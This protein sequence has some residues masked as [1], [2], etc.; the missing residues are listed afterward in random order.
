MKPSRYYIERLLS[1]ANNKWWIVCIKPNKND[2][3]LDDDLVVYKGSKRTAE[4]WLRRLKK[5]E[6]K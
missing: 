1:R 4:K 5:Q 6:V 3:K 2:P